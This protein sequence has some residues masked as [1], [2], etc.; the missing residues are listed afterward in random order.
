M[1]LYEYRCRDCGA[2]SEI[3]VFSSDETPECRKCG[4]T[5]LEKLLSSFAVSMGSSRSS[6][7]AASCP[8]GSCCTTGT[9][10]LS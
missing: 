1:A 9:C 10:G 8:T 3:L 5:N 4:S 6:T 2:V 7:S